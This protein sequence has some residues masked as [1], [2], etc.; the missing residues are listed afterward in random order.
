MTLSATANLKALGG[1]GGA[2]FGAGSAG[3]DGAVGVIQIRGT[4]TDSGS[5]SMPMADS[6]APAL[7][8]FPK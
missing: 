8:A 4:V 1:G 2:P 5:M 6:S 3:G 7:P